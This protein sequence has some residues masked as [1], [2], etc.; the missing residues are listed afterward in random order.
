MIKPCIN[1][2]VYFQGGPLHPTYKQSGGMYLSYL[3]G[4][5]MVN[6]PIIYN[7]IEHYL[8]IVTVNHGGVH[9]RHAM[10]A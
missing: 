10:V 9:C 5:M 3:K 4:L 1:K 6:I 2:T 8:N 7:E